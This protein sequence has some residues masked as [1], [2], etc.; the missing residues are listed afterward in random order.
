MYAAADP[1][2]SEQTPEYIREC[3]ERAAADHTLR[4]NEERMR[5]ALDA[6]DMGSFTWY[7]QE[8]RCEADTRMLRLFGLPADGVLNLAEALAALIHPADRATYAAL[9][10]RAI[11]GSG[12]GK[13]HADIRA[14]HPG[15]AIRWLAI[16]GETIFSTEPRCALRMHGVAVDITERKT[17]EVQRERLLEAERVARN[18]AESAVRAKDEFLATLSH[19]LRTPLANV[20]S[21]AHVLQ[22]K[23]AGIDDQLAKGLQII[24]DNALGQAQL[25]AELLDVSR[26]TS[27]KVALEVNALRLNE[28]LDSAV[29]SHRAQAEAAGVALCLRQSAPVTIF[30]DGA[31][32]QQV[33]GNLL[34]NALKFTPA[35]GRVDVRLQAVGAW[36]EIEVADTGE[37][38]SAEVLP[39]IFERFR[40]ADSSTSRRHGGLGLGLA[41]VQ[42]IVDMHGGEVHAQ[43]DGIGKGA[44]LTVRLPV[45]TAETDAQ[46]VGADAG[47]IPAMLE[48][49][50]LKA[51]RV[52]AVEDE[53]SMRKY[54]QRVLQEHGAEVRSVSSA[55]EALELCAPDSGVAFDILI[56][57]IGL[58]DIDGNE[59][60]RR[61]RGE[62][63]ISADRLP[64]LAVTAFARATDREQV[65]AA[66]F[67]AHLAKPFDA[68]HLAI[69]VRQL[70]SARAGRA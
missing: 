3:A 34:S 15:G 26:M 20:V 52:L 59:L 7:P 50:S 68:A 62:L 49:D 56:S 1:A 58:P 11:D 17:F 53:P 43:S 30:G 55:R 36:A 29:T 61:I 48:P 70:S 33:L 28:V 69:V 9:V 14:V 60:I 32:L 51:V 21:W 6:A 10:A 24:V 2:C 67:Q 41:I 23:F 54:L 46:R 47:A 63:A 16:S 40:Q 27:G 13:L 44:R 65:L 12:T 5:L 37:G 19:E 25:I 45:A 64:A 22:K 66:G 57:D 35:G 42:Q 4:V 31:R 8:D 39:H 38:I 18:E